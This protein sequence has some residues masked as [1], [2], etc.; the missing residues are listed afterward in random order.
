MLRVAA[1]IRH[2]NEPA[3]LLVARLQGSAR[4]NHLTPAIQEYGRIVKTVSILR[5]LHDEQHRRRILA[6]RP[7]GSTTSTST[8]ITTSPTPTTTQ[9]P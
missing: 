6:L 9:R 3:S 2:G 8:A 7:P 1:T 4:Q 5:Y